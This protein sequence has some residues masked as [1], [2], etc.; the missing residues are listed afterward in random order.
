M[1]AVTTSLNTALYHQRV[2][3]GN[4][5]FTATLFGKPN[6]WS[7]S[8]LTAQEESVRIEFGARLGNVLWD[9]RVGNAFAPNPT[10]FTD[11]IINPRELTTSIPAGAMRV[12]RNPNSP[13]DG[14]PLEGGDAYVVSPSSC[15]IT[16]MVAGSNM[17]ALHT[18]R[19]CLI[20]RHELLYGSS[21]RK[22]HSVCFSALAFLGHAKKTYVKVFWGIRGH[23]FRH[24]FS[25]PTYGDVNRAM[26]ELIVSRWG[27]QNAP[28]RDGEFHLDLP[29]LIKAQ[30]MSWGV[31]ETHI[32][33]AHA[34]SDSSEAWVD[35]AVGTPRNLVVINRLA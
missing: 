34:Y 2:A 13:A 11:R 28:V 30:C 20:D 10:K 22:T 29:Q 24:S 33:L 5:A 1:L 17:L 15:P 27:E 4:T 32:D 12:R 23:K 21:G 8:Q 35:G 18:G 26:H 6:N 9:L 7:L 25:H 16:V 14:I 31:P 19:D 3:L